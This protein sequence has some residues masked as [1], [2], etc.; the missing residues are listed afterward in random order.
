MILVDTGG[1]LFVPVDKAQ[2]IGLRLLLKT[3]EIPTLLD[4]LMTVS[5]VVGD[6]KQRVQELLALYNS[7]S[8]FD[9]AEIVKSLTVLSRTK[10]LSSR[11]QWVLEKAM[12]FLV[13]EISEVL[14]ETRSAAE[15]RVT[16]AL[17]T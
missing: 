5:T 4:R 12:K 8:A 9:L 15:E 7:G 16:R 1:E 11:E 14:G 10:P 13:C 6:R 17:C 3:S 2:A